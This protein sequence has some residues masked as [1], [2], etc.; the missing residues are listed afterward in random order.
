MQIVFLPDPKA[1]EVQAVCL[2][3]NLLYLPIT[4]LAG[5]RHCWTQ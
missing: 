3:E 1:T 5:E 4:G 2:L